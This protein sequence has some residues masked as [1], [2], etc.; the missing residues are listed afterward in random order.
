MTTYVQLKQ[1]IQAANP[2]VMEWHCEGCLRWHSEYTNGCLYCW[3]DELTREE[4]IKLFP[5]R[6]VILIS[7]PIR[8]ADVMLAIK[9]YEKGLKIPTTSDYPC[10]LIYK[11]DI[12]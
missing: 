2:G 8:L 6:K 10:C 9:N 4:N 11:S 7:R 1:V 5:N 12:G 3:R